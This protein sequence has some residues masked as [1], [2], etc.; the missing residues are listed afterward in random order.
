MAMTTSRSMAPREV[1]LTV[2]CLEE[3][4]SLMGPM[5]RVKENPG[6]LA[7]ADDQGPQAVFPAEESAIGE[8]SPGVWPRDGSN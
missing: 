3:L 1:P 6:R 2:T 4:Q 5:T 7:E 8:D